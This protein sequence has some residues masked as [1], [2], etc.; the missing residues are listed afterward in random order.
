MCIPWTNIY[1]KWLSI[2]IKVNLYHYN[3]CIYLLVY[4][5]F[6]QLW[7]YTLGSQFSLLQI[8]LQD[9]LLST[10]LHACVITTLVYALQE[11]S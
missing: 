6:N 5:V 1:D 4:R 7:Y 8:M 3:G 10:P 11:E 2:L 9:S